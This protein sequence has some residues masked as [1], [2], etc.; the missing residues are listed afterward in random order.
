MIKRKRIISGLLAALLLVA[1]TCLHAS[2]EGG[3]VK[4][5]ELDSNDSLFFQRKI[6]YSLRSL[7]YNAK[8]GDE[9]KITII[10]IDVSSKKVIFDEIIP[11]DETIE[12]KVRDLFDKIPTRSFIVSKIN[13]QEYCKD[14][15][16]NTYTGF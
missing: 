7:T 13:G 6:D 3:I 10:N 9:V 5:I 12:L 15:Y 1:L 11:V 14:V 8:A 2:H 4:A 16:I